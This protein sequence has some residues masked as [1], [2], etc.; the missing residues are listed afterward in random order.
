MRPPDLP[1]SSG[2]EVGQTIDT[3]C[4]V[5]SLLSLFQCLSYALAQIKPGIPIWAIL[6]ICTTA[7]RPLTSSSYIVIRY[8]QSET[9][10]QDTQAQ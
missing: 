3:A 6:A 8:Y 7:S 1:I 5:P 2:G 10:V 9:I 4:L